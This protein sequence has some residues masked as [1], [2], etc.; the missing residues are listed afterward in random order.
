MS[1]AS[2]KSIQS[3]MSGIATL[4]LDSLIVSEYNTRC[5]FV[6][7]DHVEHLAK[8]IAERGFLPIRPLLVNVI[9][10]ASGAI[11]SRRLVAGLHRYKGSILAELREAPCTQFEGLT[12]EE[13]CLLDRLDNEMD[14]DHKKAPFLAEAEHYR[15]LIEQKGWS[16]RQIAQTKGVS[17]STVQWKLQIAALP[18]QV[19]NTIRGCHN[20][21]TLVEGHFRE[22][23]KLKSAGHMIL[24]I[25]EI[26][27]RR[28][29]A[30]QEE[31]ECTVVPMKHREILNRVAELLER[32]S[33]GEVAPEVAE[34]AANSLP[35]TGEEDETAEQDLPSPS[36]LTAGGAPGQKFSKVSTKVS[37]MLDAPA[38]NE[39][40]A[41]LAQMR[42]QRIEEMKAQGPLG[43]VSDKRSTAAMKFDVIPRWIKCSSLPSLLKGDWL[44]FETLLK[45]EMRYKHGLESTQAEDG[46][47][48]IGGRES[49]PGWAYQFLANMLQQKVATIQKK[50]RYL[51]K[52]ELIK[53]KKVPLPRYPQFQICWESLKK[54]Y[55]QKAWWIPFEEGGVDQMPPNYS[56]IIEPTPV[57]TIWVREGMVIKGIDYCM[58]ETLEALEQLGASGKFARKLVQEYHLGT[59]R[60]LLVLLPTQIET[61]EQTQG[62]A[63]REPLNFFLSRLKAIP[64][65]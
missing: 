1:E 32:E 53:I 46:Y 60:H 18:E 24:I 2:Y 35:Q 51:E 8:R 20:C 23:C 9:R 12:P 38:P 45:Y 58:K 33:R 61:Y 5:A 22:I 54:L 63:V 39:E 47:F 65:S 11:S 16:H 26:I 34:M 17:R 49:T 29:A 56:G 6:D 14:E 15:Y 27:S 3:K 36:P 21:G 10:N 44:L 13:E 52:I 30:D 55:D 43:V 57:H 28:E 4:P 41:A 31:G 40:E 48:F 62:E 64:K 7:Q 37:P 50:L 19:K 59:L 42:Q 25:K